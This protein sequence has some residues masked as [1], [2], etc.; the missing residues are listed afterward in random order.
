MPAWHEARRE[1]PF[2]FAGSAMASAG[3]A[4]LVLTPARHAAPARRLLVAGAVV[5]TVAS[6]V[7]EHRL[8]ELAKPYRSGASGRLSRAALAATSAGAATA[9]AAGGHRAGAIAAGALTLAG[10]A[11]ERFA[12]IEAGFA[13]ARDP[14]ATTGPQRRR[15]DARRGGG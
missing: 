3:A 6:R 7:M 1:L 2:V 10:S 11:L 9:A 12:V 15:L 4:A 8:G 5:E 13:S 14:E